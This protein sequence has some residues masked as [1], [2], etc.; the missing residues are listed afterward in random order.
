MLVVTVTQA[1][2]PAISPPS[3]QPC[4]L[5]RLHTLLKPGTAE[6]G[7]GLLIGRICAEYVPECLISVCQ[8]LEAGS[9]PETT[10]PLSPETLISVLGVFWRRI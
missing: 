3:A 9:L 4:H 5:A 8:A 1:G 6:H 10:I 7:R 2:I